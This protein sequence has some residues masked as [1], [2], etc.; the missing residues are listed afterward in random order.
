MRRPQPSLYYSKGCTEAELHDCWHF[1]LNRAPGKLSVC[2]A[3][4]SQ[5]NILENPDGLQSQGDE[6]REMLLEFFEE[7]IQDR[8]PE[9]DYTFDVYITI[10][11]KVCAPIA[12]SAWTLV[13]QA[14]HKP[15]LQ[16]DILCSGC[17]T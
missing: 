7:H 9:D 4:I 6:L 5:R 10:A 8:F 17:W 12:L 15:S 14:S 1:M 11:G 3:A 2:R 13:I 16:A